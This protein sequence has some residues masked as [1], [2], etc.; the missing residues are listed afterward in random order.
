M[1]YKVT[2]KFSLIAILLLFAFCGHSQRASQRSSQQATAPTYDFA[3]AEVKL[4]ELFEIAVRGENEHI[5]YNANERFLTLLKSTL[6]E[7]GAFDFPFESVRAEKLM[8]PDRKFRMFNWVIQ[9][10]QGMEFFAVM[11][12][13]IERT[14]EYRIIQLIDENETIFDLDHAILGKDNWFGAHYRQVILTESGSRKYYTLIGWNGND[15][16]VTRRVIEILTFRPNGDP[17]FGAAIFTGLRGRRER[18]T[19]KVFEHRRRSSM[20]LRYDFQAYHEPIGTPRPGQRQRERLVRTNMIVFDRL[21][22]QSPELRGR[23]ETYIAAGG[24]YDAFVWKN[25]RW[26]LKTDIRARNPDPPRN[27]RR[28]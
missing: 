3:T 11:M 19:R 21:I 6:A 17:V 15:R 27:R 7:N 10:E 16:A 8:A 26:T 5:R 22:P 25:G 20:I 2:K 13:Y 28:R 23:R 12:V 14:R 4:A 18:I 1:K 9:R 24:V